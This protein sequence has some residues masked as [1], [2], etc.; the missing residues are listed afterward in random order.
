MKRLFG[1]ILGLSLMLGLST[2]TGGLTPEAQVI[3]RLLPLSVN[4]RGEGSCSGVWVGEDLI[5]TAKHCARGYRAF[6]TT[7]SIR[8]Y[9]G[10]RY[11]AKLILQGEGPGVTHD[12]ALL[13]T[14]RPQQGG[15]AR[16]SCEATQYGQRVIGIGNA[17]GMTGLLPYLGE[18][19]APEF[20][21]AETTGEAN[22]WRHGI[23]TTMHGAPGVSGGP[24]FNL[25]GELVGLLVGSL[26]MSP[27]GLIQQVTFPAQYISVLCGEHEDG[28]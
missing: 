26:V 21:V 23:L 16:A 1:L 6:E 15:W 18:V 19:N 17:L 10:D 13:R 2:A 12:W 5:L 8:S 7:Y 28:G 3:P 25:D 24:V 22:A 9:T 20:N 27:F 11:D 4:V 14:T